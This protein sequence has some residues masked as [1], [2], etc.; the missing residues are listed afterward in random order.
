MFEAS[1]F[2]CSYSKWFNFART[3]N[4]Y[5]G[6]VALVSSEFEHSTFYTEIN[7]AATRLLL[8][9]ADQSHALKLET[10]RKNGFRAVD[11][12]S[13]EEVVRKIRYE[14]VKQNESERK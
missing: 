7:T 2:A 8:L 6:Q 1:G 13:I 5:Q 12:N 9:S 14:K 4:S 11:G 10:E 3:E